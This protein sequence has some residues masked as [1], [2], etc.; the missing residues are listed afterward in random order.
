MLLLDII[1]QTIF[2]NCFCEIAIDIAI[3]NSIFVI[4]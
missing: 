2:N 4:Q 3:E 1:S